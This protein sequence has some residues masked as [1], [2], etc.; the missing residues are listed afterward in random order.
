MLHLFQIAHYFWTGL[1][2]MLLF[3]YYF[4]S[5]YFNIYLL[6]YYI[7]FILNLISL[8]HN[9]LVPGGTVFPFGFYLDRTIK[10]HLCT[11]DNLLFMW[12]A[13]T[14]SF[15]KCVGNGCSEY[16]AHLIDSYI[17]G[18]SRLNESLWIDLIRASYFPCTIILVNIWYLYFITCPAMFFST[19]FHQKIKIWIVL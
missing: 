9:L 7:N 6:F 14:C 11:K 1:L 2:L 18:C 4:F 8:D 16:P 12:I 19:D 15:L 10:A 3:R 13:E 5:I 17:K